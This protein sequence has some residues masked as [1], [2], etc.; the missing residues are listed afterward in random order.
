MGN[1]QSQRVRIV[2]LYCRG[3]ANS[4]SAWASFIYQIPNTLTKRN[5]L[6]EEVF[7]HVDMQAHAGLWRFYRHTRD[8]NTAP[9]YLSSGIQV[10]SANAKL[11]LQV[12]NSIY[13][14]Y[15]SR[16]QKITARKLLEQY[17]AYLDWEVELPEEISLPY[18]IADTDELS[19]I[20]PHVISLQ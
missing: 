2:L 12:Q 15:H 5:P 14:L 18:G 19:Q 13:I 9:E 4:S 3:E 17:R 10:A 8:T 11:M 16:D 1:L 20:V 6:T 7:K